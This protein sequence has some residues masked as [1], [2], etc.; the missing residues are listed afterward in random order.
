M[1]EEL[2]KE[3]EYLKKRIEFL[4]MII[5]VNQESLRKANDTNTKLLT[6]LKKNFK[7]QK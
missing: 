4:E 2:R 3:N 5:E 7:N 1:E 6:W